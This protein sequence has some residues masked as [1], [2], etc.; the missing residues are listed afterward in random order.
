MAF[1]TTLEKKHSSEAVVQCG[2]LKCASCIRKVLIYDITSEA[3]NIHFYA[4]QNLFC[5]FEN[6]VNHFNCFISLSNLLYK[7][8]FKGFKCFS[9]DKKGWKSIKMN[10][11]KKR[12][13]QIWDNRIV[14]CNIVLR[15]PVLAAIFS[16]TLQ[17]WQ[18]IVQWPT[19]LPLLLFGP[20]PIKKT[21]LSLRSSW[22]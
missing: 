18:K 13:I 10:N 14:W 16:Q 12:K 9:K 19:T 1:F 21:L 17:K 8:N 4:L 22:Y 3:S 7:N 6:F 2:R 20:F 15:H 11:D 5:P